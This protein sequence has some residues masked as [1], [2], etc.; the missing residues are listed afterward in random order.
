MLR[1]PDF[2]HSFALREFKLRAEVVAGKTME[3]ILTYART[4]KFAVFCNYSCSEDHEEMTGFIFATEW[5]VVQVTAQVA[6]RRLY[7]TWF[8]FGVTG[9]S[10]NSADHDRCVL[11]LTF[12][13]ISVTN[14]T[15]CVRHNNQGLCRL[16]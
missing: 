7:A 9:P 4:R 16:N 12:L 6:K 2:V 8:A 3:L 13:D 10:A 14:P 1:R 15:E 5:L 11:F